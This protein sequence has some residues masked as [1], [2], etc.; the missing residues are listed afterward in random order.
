MIKPKIKTTYADAIKLAENG[1][2]KMIPL[3][4]EIFSDMH[5]P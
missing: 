4:A 3:T 5:T 1:K 2:Y